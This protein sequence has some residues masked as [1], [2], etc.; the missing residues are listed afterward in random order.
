[1]TGDEL[2][3][4]RRQ[5]DMSQEKLAKRLQVV[6]LTVSRWEN[7]HTSIPEVAAM[8]IRSLVKEEEG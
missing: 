8:A 4:A 7:N 6:T 1:M 3:E 5:L 2:K